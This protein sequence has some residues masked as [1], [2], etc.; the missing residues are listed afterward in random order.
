[1]AIGDVALLQA[2][3]AHW[4]LILL[5]RKSVV[6]V[7]HFYF[8]FFFFNFVFLAPRVTFISRT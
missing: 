7:G 6:A 5:V 4:F 1:M 2:I 3:L 8:L